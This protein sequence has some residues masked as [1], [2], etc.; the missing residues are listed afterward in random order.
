MLQR[1]VDPAKKRH[2]VLAAI[3]EGIV[4]G[5]RQHEEE[6]A[7]IVGMVAIACALLGSLLL[8]GALLAWLM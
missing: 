4:E 1:E 3:A 7:R 2:D 6:E 5:V 8:G